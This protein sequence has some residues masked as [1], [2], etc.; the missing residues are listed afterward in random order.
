MEVVIPPLEGQQFSAAEMA[1]HIVGVDIVIAGDDDIGASVLDAGKA[2]SLKA[3]IKWGI[4]TDGIDKPHAARVGIPVY[5]T[6]GV[7]GEEVADLAISHLLMLTRKTHL[8]DRS[9]RTG[10]WL[11]AE[12][13]TLSGLTA[14]VIGLG[15]IGQAIARRAAA[16][17][18]VVVGYDVARIESADLDAIGATQAPFDAV[19]ERA[20]VLFLAC[21][22]MPE[23]RHLIGRETLARVKPGV[24]IINVSRG[25]LVDEV[26]LAQAL[27]EGRVAGAGLDV[28]EEEPLPESSP[29]RG[30][31]D[32][33]TFSTHNGSNT[34]EAV[35]RINQ[36]TTDI[37]F[38]VLGVKKASFV[39]N[40][41]V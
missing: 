41:V 25:P 32:R 27:A 12:G 15:S 34:V 40:R 17:G 35:A 5:N 19:L 36:M 22:L 7:F 37:A 39:A 30:Y 29:L 13:R 3:V 14:G 38:D 1:R 10:G 33:C 9:V 2:S 11:K 18:M 23:N 16:F 24:F 28:F 8:M 6:P 21:A 26:A 31:E 4:G 20:D